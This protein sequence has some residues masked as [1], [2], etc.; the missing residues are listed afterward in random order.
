MVDDTMPK[1]HDTKSPLGCCERCRK[2]ELAGRARRR[3]VFRYDKV[4]AA[5]RPSTYDVFHGEQLVATLSRRRTSGP[6]A[7][8]VNVPWD[9]VTGALTAATLRD[10]RDLAEETYTATWREGGHTT[11]GPVREL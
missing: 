5:E 9:A 4:E 10:A 11:R 2:A 7:Y 1:L 3:P 6:D 8:S